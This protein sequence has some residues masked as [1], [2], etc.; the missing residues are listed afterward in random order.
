M[1]NVIYVRSYQRKKAGPTAEF[2][3]KTKA[4]AAQVLVEREWNAFIGNVLAMELDHALSEPLDAV[5][6]PEEQRIRVRE[7]F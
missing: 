6:M 7:S 5:D 2:V 1:S 3:S 4:L